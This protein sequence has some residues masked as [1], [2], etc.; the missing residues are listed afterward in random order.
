MIA[1]NGFTIDNY[2]DVCNNKCNINTINKKMGKTK[3]TI[4]KNAWRKAKRFF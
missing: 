1:S 2:N 3:E 4:N